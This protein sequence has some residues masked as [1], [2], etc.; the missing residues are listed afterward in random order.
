MHRGYDLIR[1]GLLPALKLGSIKILIYEAT[2]CIN[3]PKQ[4]L[5]INLKI[6]LIAVINS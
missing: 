6:Y 4:I 5:T 1:A 3:I 2:L